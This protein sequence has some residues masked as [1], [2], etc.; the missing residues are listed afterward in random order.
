M[1]IK[2]INRSFV[3]P[4]ELNGRRLD[5]LI[6]L[7]NNL[8]RRNARNI[9]EKGLVLVNGMRITF[10]SKK[11]NKDDKIV[12]IETG[13]EIN[14]EPALIYEDNVLI[15]VN[16]PPGYLSEKIGTEK[17][18]A[19]NEILKRKGKSVY[20][21]H[22]LDRETSGVMV[23]A[24]TPSARDFLIAEFKMRKVNKTYIGIIE[25]HLQNKKG[26]L[27]GKLLKTGEYAVTD[28]E[29]MKE[30][31]GACLLKL[32]PKTGRT[33]QLRLQL[34]QIGHPVVGDKKYYNIKKTKIFFQR[35]ALHSYEISF[36]HPETKKWISFT[37]PI[38][39]DM[40]QLI[41]SLSL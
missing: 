20:P 9:V 12:I 36:V 32:M 11:V 15:V 30:L 35:Q 22:R 34:A 18:K 33:H 41:K 40:K 14:L 17:G 1:N 25:G 29:V 16:K 13:E 38:P 24:R 26:V 7:F 2:I 27:K 6:A 19:V 21:V 23:F 3:V 37:A 28:Y 4:G 5:Y 10:P 39:E 31:K 8:S